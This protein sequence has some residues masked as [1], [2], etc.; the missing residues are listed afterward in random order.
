[1]LYV[2]VCVQVYAHV[3]VYS[4]L[5]FLELYPMIHLNP[6]PFSNRNTREKFL[7][8]L[9][10][11]KSKNETN[12]GEHFLFFRSGSLPSYLHFQATSPS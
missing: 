7:L 9:L 5:H 6:Y 2:H 1:M 3:I 11:Q 10:L 12:T 8:P 4:L